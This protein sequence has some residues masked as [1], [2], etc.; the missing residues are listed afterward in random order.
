MRF[1]EDF[2]PNLPGQ[3]VPVIT[4]LRTQYELAQKA[5]RELRG[6]ADVTVASA[7]LAT[8]KVQTLEAE[9]VAL[10]A[11]ITSLKADHDVLNANTLLVVEKY[12]EL[13][14]KV[15]NVVTNPSTGSAPIT[16]SA[17]APTAS[18]VK[19]SEPPKFKGNKGSDITLEQWLQKM[20]L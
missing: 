5:V 10:K 12:K 18:K 9:N 20:G 1:R 7:K 15:N 8:D 11:E 3:S 13:A 16:I 4:Q 2:C 6:K 19:A 14:A 17:P